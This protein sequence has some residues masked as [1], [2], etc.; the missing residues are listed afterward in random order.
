MNINWETWDFVN[1]ERIRYSRLPVNASGWHGLAL[2]L[3]ANTLFTGHI[4][5]SVY[6]VD[7]YLGEGYILMA[8]GM[9]PYET[10]DTIRFSTGIDLQVSTGMNDTVL[11]VH[12]PPSLRLAYSA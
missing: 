1:G 12:S 7:V 9:R 10:G 5:Q 11:F 3:P 8:G 4:S 2:L 6:T